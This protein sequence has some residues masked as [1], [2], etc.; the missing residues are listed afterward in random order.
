[1]RFIAPIAILVVTVTGTRRSVKAR[2]RAERAAARE[3]GS[4]VVPVNSEDNIPSGPAVPADLAVSDST[5]GVAED[6]KHTFH[7]DESHPA[8]TGAL[9]ADLTGSV[10][11]HPAARGVSSSMNDQTPAVSVPASPENTHRE[12]VLYVPPV[13]PSNSN[14]QAEAERLQ[15]RAFEF[16]RSKILYPVENRQPLRPA[17]AAGAAHIRPKTPNGDNVTPPRRDNV[18][19]PRRDN[20]PPV[21]AQE[22]TAKWSKGMKVGGGVA[23]VA[24]LATG[25][26]YSVKNIRAGDNKCREQ[27]E[28]ERSYWCKFVVNANNF[29]RSAT[30]FFS[31]G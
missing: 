29:G 4:K 18:T 23:L 9:P 19:P 10:D 6:N 3:Q 13:P 28:E 27:T 26:V 20:V 5:T 17:G 25:A 30:K 16:L 21:A 24:G 7:T 31:R 2:L 11:I 22:A 8:S 15:R 14:D 12:L 1:M